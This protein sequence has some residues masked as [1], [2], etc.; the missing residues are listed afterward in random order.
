MSDGSSANTFACN[1]GNGC[2]SINNIS[3]YAPACP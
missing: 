2:W 3:F 1:Q